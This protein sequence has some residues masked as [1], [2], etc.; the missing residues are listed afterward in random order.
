M[1]LHPKHAPFP[2]YAFNESQEEA[3]EMSQK[4]IE[5]PDNPYLCVAH[6][7]VTALTTFELENPEPPSLQSNL[8]PSDFHLFEP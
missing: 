7:T 8:T 5:L 2:C 6:L 3:W 4:N 1:M